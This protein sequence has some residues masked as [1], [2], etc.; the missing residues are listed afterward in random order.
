MCEKKMRQRYQ[1]SRLFLKED[2]LFINISEAHSTRELYNEYTT[3]EEER[4][5]EKSVVVSF[6][7]ERRP[8]SLLIIFF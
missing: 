7:F 6:F 2:N 1:K 5:Y 8:A 4:L 3:G